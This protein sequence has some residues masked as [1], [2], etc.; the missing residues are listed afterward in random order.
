MLLQFT[1]T[2]LLSAVTLQ[3]LTG[4]FVLFWP[5]SSV[6]MDVHR[7]GAW[8]LLALLPWKILIAYRSLAKGLKRTFDR[9]VVP[10]V[11]S[12]L[13]AALILVLAA[14][15]AWTWRIG[16]WLVILGQTVIS[17]HW[18]LGLGL[19]PFFAIHTW[20]RWPNPRRQVLLSRRSALRTLGMLLFGAVGWQAAELVAE[21]RQVAEHARSPTTGSRQYNSFQGNAFPVTTNF[22]ENP[23]RLDPKAWS[24]D[25]TGKVERPLSL[26]YDQL[27]HLPPSERTE[28]LDCTVGWYSIQRWRG[29]PLMELVQRARPK[30]AASFIRLWADTGYMKTF[31]FQQAKGILLATHVGGE[32]LSHPHGFPLRAVVP[33]WRGWFWVKWLT[34]VEILA[35]AGTPRT[36]VEA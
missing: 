28:T 2:A 5:V 18:V 31:T 32:Q 25:L 22:G 7:I 6:V 34:Q 36:P 11:S 10:I 17:W 13:A 21:R 27:I 1:N 29:V 4:L 20:S 19:I 14:G 9:G 30:P 3:L 24:L 12:L 35:S 26:T 33:G 23:R 15:F 8:A 16:E